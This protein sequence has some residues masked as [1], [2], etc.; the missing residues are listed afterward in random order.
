MRLNHT[1][2]QKVSLRLALDYADPVD[3]VSSWATS[4]LPVTIAANGA[5]LLLWAEPSQLIPR[6]LPSSG[7]LPSYKVLYGD[8]LSNQAIK[9]ELTGFLW[10]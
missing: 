4:L 1:E 8:A 3:A 7:S 2:Q 10:C 6:R 5:N 9:G